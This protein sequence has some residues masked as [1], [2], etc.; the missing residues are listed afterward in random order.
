MQFLRVALILLTTLFK[1]SEGSFVLTAPKVA[2][3]GTPY[4]VSIVLTEPRNAAQTGDI[5]MTRFTHTNHIKTQSFTI[6]QTET[7]K[8]VQISI[9]PGNL[10]PDKYN[11]KIIMVMDGRTINQT[12]TIDLV[13]DT[14]FCMIQTDK[15]MYKRSQTVKFRVVCLDSDLM[16]ITNEMDITIIDPDTNK[17]EMFRKESSATGVI[18]QEYPLSDDPKLGVWQIQVQQTDGRGKVTERN[19]TVDE[20]VLPRFSVEVKSVPYIYVKD[21]SSVQIEVVAMYTYG[22]PVH[23]MASVAFRLKDTNFNK[24]LQLVD[25]KASFV[26]STADIGDPS[27][28]KQNL[29]NDRYCY[30]MKSHSIPMSIHA[31]VMENETDE[32]QETK[33][34]LN[35]YIEPVSIEFVNKNAYRKNMP[36]TAYVHI[37]DPTKDPLPKSERYKYK[38]NYSLYSNDDQLYTETDVALPMDTDDVILKFTTSTNVNQIDSIQ[39][40]LLDQSGTVLL[41]KKDSEVYSYKSYSNAGVQITLMNS[42]NAADGVRSATRVYDVGDTMHI[43]TTGY[44]QNGFKT[45]L[46]LYVFAKGK[47]VQSYA[48]SSGDITDILIDQTMSLAPSA[49]L[50]LYSVNS[51]NELIADEMAIFV[52]GLVKNQ[53]TMAFSTERQQV[54]RDVTLQVTSDPN[55]H[56]FL[57]A[58][59]KG[60]QLLKKPNDITSD[61][62]KKAVMEYNIR[63]E[64]KKDNHWNP[65]FMRGKRSVPRKWYYDGT[66]AKNIFETVGVVYLT[67]ATVAEVEDGGD[68]NAFPETARSGGVAADINSGQNKQDS[69]STD[70]STSQ[71]RKNFPETWIWLNEMVGS[72]GSYSTTLKLPDTITSW[73]T[74]GFS[75]SPTRGLGIARNVQVEAFKQFFVVVSLPPTAFRGEK[76]EVKLVVFNYFGQQKSVIVTLK[77]SQD[78]MMYSDLPT[79]TSQPL[80]GDF[81]KTFQVAAGLS[82][83]TSL[84]ISPTKVGNIMLQVEAK[85]GP[86]VWDSSDIVQKVIPIDPEGKTEYKSV[87]QLI[88]ASATQQIMTVVPDFP[89]N[90]VPDSRKV[91]IAVTGDI[92]GQSLQNLDGMIRVPYGCGEQNMISLVPNIYALSYMKAAGI[93]KPEI[94]TKAK[95]N[96]KQGYQR[97]LNYK[98]DNGGFSAFGKNDNSF[99][100]WLTAFV[101]KSFS[102]AKRFTF[103]SD[104]V[105]LK[106]KEAI[107]SQSNKDGSFNEP[108]IV[109]HKDMMTGTSSGSMLTAYIYIALKETQNSG[110]SIPDTFNSSRTL[111]YLENFYKST[112]HVKTPFQLAVLSYCFSLGNSQEL[113][114]VLSDLAGSSTITDNNDMQCWC[115][116]EP[117]MIGNKRTYMSYD[118]KPS[119]IET[120]SYV[121]LAYIQQNDLTNGI[122]IMKW[123]MT[124]LNGK[125]GFM[126]TQDTVM[127]LQALSRYA[128]LLSS[129]DHDATVT[130][131]TVGH[132]D[133]MFTVDKDTSI[134]LQKQE[135]PNIAQIAANGVEIIV[136]GTGNAVVSV[137]WEYNLDVNDG[138]PDLHVTVQTYKKDYYT[139][140]IDTCIWYEGSDDPGMGMTY[141][142]I[143]TGYFV[144][145]MADLN[146]DIRIQR[147][148][149]EGRTLNMYFNSIS[150]KKTCISVFARWEY[151]V[152][153]HKPCPVRVQL[154][155][156]P[157]KQKTTYYSVSSQ[158][159]PT[160]GASGMT[161]SMFFLTFVMAVYALFR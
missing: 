112:T 129:A 75:I 56:I 88:E 128:E 19:I 69:I 11:L 15:G 54:G 97:E 80:S 136:Q 14:G 123:L 91:T 117:K 20:Y 132:A 38:V 121:L 77:H 5:V 109:H 13:D 133:V 104:D 33:S 50:L 111:T 119:A 134:L 84:Y 138:I 62:A 61:Q 60:S 79:Y 27:A 157:E 76:I 114:N 9:M 25:G 58:I 45:P 2:R 16:P 160:G 145:N 4:I 150:R 115:N 85:S 53:M 118:V 48:V 125:G 108:G 149:L 22:E 130:F 140:E 28:L 78:F 18:T 126:S 153:D 93:A 10:V 23:G 42:A 99:S 101:M 120:A 90:F 63:D 124:Q 32:E 52:S 154:Y 30:N 155:Y 59:D 102:Q 68:L 156:A 158:I 47:Q 41:I 81:R 57:V 141:V 37:T 35:F 161:S 67:D 98:H 6:D 159:K 127:G 151:I 8:D 89:P 137:N 64:K 122:P 71:I 146:K 100:S 55:S 107:M 34:T 82:K 143:P 74:R 147:V 65:W 66:A 31:K 83:G 12:T 39:V 113:E 87:Q 103:I 92:M 26:V 24:R 96:M 152:V 46:F 49:S 105:L 94:E 29:C 95:K 44:S 142:D 40:D 73:T 72:D 135:L 131:K 51:D 7:K 139:I 116:M 86:S 3:I 36:Y 21:F 110:D 17:V 144:S 1:T 70:S 106:A 43:G 148:E